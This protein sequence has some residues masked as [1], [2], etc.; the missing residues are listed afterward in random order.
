MLGSM[1]KSNEPQNV[2]VG[3]DT[4]ETIPE[5]SVQIEK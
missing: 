5:E 2:K 1:K 4:P 3:V